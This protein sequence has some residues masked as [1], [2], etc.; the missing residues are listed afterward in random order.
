MTTDQLCENL[1]L[2]TNPS[3]PHRGRSRKAR[4]KYFRSRRYHPRKPQSELS[5]KL[6]EPPDAVRP[7][8]GVGTLKRCGDQFFHSMGEPLS[9]PI[10]FSSSSN[11]PGRKS[12]QAS[13]TKAFHKQAIFF[14]ATPNPVAFHPFVVEDSDASAVEGN[15]ICPARM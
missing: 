15:V 5:E 1:T 4:S 12:R 10:P 9:E 2:S 7:N 3:L 11:L 13:L 14:I 6:T 8:S